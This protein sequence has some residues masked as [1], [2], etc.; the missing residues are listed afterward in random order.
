MTR[1][2]EQLALAEQAVARNYAPLPVVLAHGTGAWVTDVDGRRYLDLL[3][4][5]SALNFGHCDPE[6]VAVAQE[7]LATLTL[8][9]RAFHHDRLA[10]FCAELAELASVDAVRVRGL[11]AG[12]D[13]RGRTGRSVCEGLLGRGVLA[14]DT[15]GA[16][17]R[18]APP[19]VID[20]A[21]LRWGIARLA[22]ALA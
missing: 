11:W 15:H 13:V 2:A 20:S 8:T 12:V 9:S 4:G 6:F 3:S 22:E 19:L 21:D 14:K 18:L 5:Y 10:T 17:I 16:T 1:T 7:Q